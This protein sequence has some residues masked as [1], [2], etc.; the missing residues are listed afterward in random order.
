M[1]RDKAAGGHSTLKK[2]KRHFSVWS[3]CFPSHT[4]THTDEVKRSLCV[5]VL[6]PWWRDAFPSFAAVEASFIYTNGRQAHSCAGPALDRFLKDAREGKSK[7]SDPSATSLVLSFSL[8]M[9]RNQILDSTYY[10]LRKYCRLISSSFLYTKARHFPVQSNRLYL[11]S[12]FSFSFYIT[13]RW[14]MYSPVKW[15]LTE[16]CDKR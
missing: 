15:S 11:L 14:K 8:L 9:L 12:T 5:L 6:C 4:H 3:R 13:F 1:N 2:K 7:E 16:R 10:S